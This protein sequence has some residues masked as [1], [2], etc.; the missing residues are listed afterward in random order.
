MGYF[1]RGIEPVMNGDEL[2][3]QEIHDA[4]RPKIVRYLA[5]LVGLRDAED[6]AQEVFIKVSQS[7]RTFRGDSQLSTWIY[8]VATN[9]A[10]DKLRSPSFR[11]K[12]QTNLSEEPAAENI[13]QIV[14]RETWTG[15]KKP[16]LET[17]LIRK[18]MNECIRGFVENLPRN[19]RTVVVLSEIEGFK[20]DEIAEILGVSIQAAKIRLHRA[21]A[22]LKKELEIHCHFY[23]DERNEF[24][25]DRKESTELKK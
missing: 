5:H 17:S 4:F 13:V 7:L 21:R 24:S 3:F 11:Q 12:G 6:I 10:L 22:R 19:Y 16:S 14:D 23:R 25:C 18:E 8:R 20:D 9:A 2:Q 1:L 15:E